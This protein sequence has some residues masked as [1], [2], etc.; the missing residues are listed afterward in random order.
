[1]SSSPQTAA[2]QYNNQDGVK[3][4]MLHRMEKSVEKFARIRLKRQAI[5]SIPEVQQRID[6]K[7][8]QHT[9]GKRKV[10]AKK[11]EAARAAKKKR[12]D[13]LSQMLKE[14]GSDAAKKD[15]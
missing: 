11:E 6:Q 1:M 10:T 12:R 2:P 4:D 5:A 9:R 8:A 14:W 3:M 15:E 13:V 7:Q